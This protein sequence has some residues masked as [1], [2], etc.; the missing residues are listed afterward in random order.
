NDTFFV[1][2]LGISKIEFLIYNRWGE[3]MFKST[4]VGE[5]WNGSHNGEFLPPD[6][7]GYYVKFSCIDSS[8]FIKKGN[9]SLL[10]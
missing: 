8:E 4:E 3:E 10:R 1:R 6:V 5:G 9:V 2:S 7:Y